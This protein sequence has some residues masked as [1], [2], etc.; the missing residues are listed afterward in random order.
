MAASHVLR[1]AKLKGNGK[2]LAAARHNRR[3]IQNEIGA[4]RHINA[5]R[6]KL[7]YSLAGAET[8]EAIAAEAKAM[9][10]AAGI[11][12]PRKDFVAAV[13]IVYSLPISHRVDERVFFADCLEWTHSHFRCHVLSF[14]VHLDE[15]TPHAH[16][17]LLPLVDGRLV[18]SDMVGNRTRLKALQAA[19]YADVGVRHGLQKPIPRLSG[20]A[21][22]K[23]ESS[24]LNQLKSDPAMQSVL[25]PRIRDLIRNDPASF[26]SLLGLRIVKAKPNKSAVAIMTSKG[27][28]SNPIGF[29]TS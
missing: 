15:S 23:T 14:D 10:Q 26:A 9:M 3:A 19:F 24:V 21:K 2:I 13:E 18:G 5:T 25:W 1:L 28:G 6:S 20:Q 29:N 11:E 8:P 12:K 7:N 22:A 27:R 4:G 16:V 17:L